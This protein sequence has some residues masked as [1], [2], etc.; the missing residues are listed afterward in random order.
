M[1]LRIKR[2][3]RS[4]YKILVQIGERRARSRQYYL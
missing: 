1:Q 3:L 4:V 2:W